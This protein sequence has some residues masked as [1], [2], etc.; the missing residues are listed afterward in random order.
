MAKEKNEARHV[1]HVW[2][3]NDDK[4]RNA[5]NC[6]DA[7]CDYANAHLF[8]LCE[9]LGIEATPE[10]MALCANEKTARAVALER[11]TESELN[12][13][14]ANIRKRLAGA[15]IDDIK[16]DFDVIFSDN[17][18][19]VELLQHCGDVH[20]YAKYLRI[21]NG[22]LS[23]NENMIIEDN[24]TYFTD[25]EYLKYKQHENICASLN[26]FLNNCPQLDALGYLFVVG[27]DGKLKPNVNYTNYTLLSAGGAFVNPWGGGFLPSASCVSPTDW[28]NKK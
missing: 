18:T 5:V 6:L 19:D 15:M 13:I 26:E 23:Y 25:D 7:F 3:K 8:T 22:V 27:D 2:R 16:I 28:I 20:L 1:W 9:A 14:P 17:Y 21:E 24:T 12:K 4:I 11:Y 10:F